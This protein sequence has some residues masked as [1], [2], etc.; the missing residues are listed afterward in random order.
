[1]TP[2]EHD[3]EAQLSFVQSH[4]RI[5][6]ITIIRPM[7]PH[8]IAFRLNNGEFVFDLDAIRDNKGNIVAHVNRIEDTADDAQRNNFMVNES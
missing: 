6:S 1:M 8:Q 4:P 3:T 5:A 2:Q 7:T